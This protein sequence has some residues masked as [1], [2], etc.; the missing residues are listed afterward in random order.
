MTL[1]AQDL[2]RIGGHVADSLALTRSLESVA[3]AW[4]EVSRRAALEPEPAYFSGMAS[5]FHD[6][7]EARRGAPLAAFERPLEPPAPTSSAQLERFESPTDAAGRPIFEGSDAA[8]FG[9][10]VGAEK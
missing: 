8:E 4:Q 5:T 3:F 9:V 7:L 1:N 6:I 2:F 10:R